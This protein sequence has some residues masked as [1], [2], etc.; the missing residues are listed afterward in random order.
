M[1][2]VNGAHAQVRWSAEVVDVAG[3]PWG[4]GVVTQRY[5]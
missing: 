3:T 5:D 4:G 1:V 2:L